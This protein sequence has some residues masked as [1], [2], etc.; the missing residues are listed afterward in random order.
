MGGSSAHR[1]VVNAV[2]ALGDVA[3]FEIRLTLAILKP[4]D[5]HVGDLQQD[6]TVAPAHVNARLPRAAVV[7]SV[8]ALAV[9]HPAFARRLGHVDLGPG[10]ANPQAVTDLP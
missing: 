1:R 6:A 8:V 3:A 7:G 9:D 2:Y 10:F 5:A 4:L